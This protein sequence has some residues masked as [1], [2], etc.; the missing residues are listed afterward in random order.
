MAQPLQLPRTL[1]FCFLWLA[2]NSPTSGLPT[3]FAPCTLEHCVSSRVRFPHC[4]GSSPSSTRQVCGYLPRISFASSSS[5]SVH[6][7]APMAITTTKTGRS[8]H[9]DEHLTGL[10]AASCS[11]H[12]PELGFLDGCCHGLKICLTITPTRGSSVS[13]SSL[14]CNGDWV[15]LFLDG[16]GGR[17]LNKTKCPASPL[18]VDPRRSPHGESTLR[19]R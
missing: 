17:E 4:P 12:A 13:R 3:T 18:T 14:A 5:S 9:E 10:A 7:K 8:S 11:A 16:A 2:G 19:T 15:M 6:D 1:F